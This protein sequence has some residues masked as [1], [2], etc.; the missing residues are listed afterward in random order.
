MGDVT[1]HKEATEPLNPYLK[2]LE[3]AQ[4]TEIEDQ[5]ISKDI[6]GIFVHTIVYLGKF[7]FW[8]CYL[9]LRKNYCN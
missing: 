2:S 7:L 4:D 5:S 6:S 8:Y 9:F 1:L 3:Q